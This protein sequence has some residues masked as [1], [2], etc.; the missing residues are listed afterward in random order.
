MTRAS[1]TD[2]RTEADAGIRLR[3]AREALESAEHDLAAFVPR[4]RLEATVEQRR[5]EV[6]RLEAEH[7]T[8]TARLTRRVHRGGGL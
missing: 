6:T 7:A 3:G 1:L 5:A 8:A 4:E 2:L